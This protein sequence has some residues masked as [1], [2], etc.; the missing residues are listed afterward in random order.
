VCG[1]IAQLGERLHGM[2][3]VRGSIPRSSTRKSIVY[4]SSGS[5]NHSGVHLGVHIRLPRANLWPS[6]GLRLK[7]ELWFPVCPP[8]SGHR[9]ARDADLTSINRRLMMSSGNRVR[10]PP[11][12]GRD[13]T[14]PGRLAEPRGQTRT[15][16]HCERFHIGR[17]H[18][19]WTR[20]ASLE[21]C[22]SSRSWL[23]LTQDND[24]PRAQV[25]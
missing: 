7:S 4:S 8:L 18:P 3:E 1:A 19:F 2:Q 21:S 9:G 23:A 6:G 20:L 11:R 22:V 17:E 13:Q 14:D 16:M 24:R 15:Q 5:Q 25:L 12:A 10:V